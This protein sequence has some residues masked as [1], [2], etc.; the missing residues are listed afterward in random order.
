MDSKILNYVGFGFL[1]LAVLVFFIGSSTVMSPV[2]GTGQDVLAYSILYLF[3][4]SI[5]C[6]I[7]GGVLNKR[8][9]TRNTH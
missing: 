1:G 6:F 3:A 7:V 9:K 8:Q 2:H 5:V 4:A